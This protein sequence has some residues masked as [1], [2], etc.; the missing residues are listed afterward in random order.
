M[1]T[2]EQMQESFEQLERGTPRLNAM[3]D[4]I[5][6]ADRA[7][8]LIWQFWFR[9]DYLRESIFCGDRY[10]AMIIF[11]ELLSLYENTQMLRESKNFSHYMLIAFRWIV[12]AAPEFPQ[13]SRKE[14]DSYFRKFKRM[15]LEQ[16]YSLSIYDSKRSLFYLD[17]DFSI[18]AVSFYRFLEEE[19]DS[20]SDGKGLWYNHQVQFYLTTGDLERAEKAAEPIFSGKVKANDIPYTTYHKFCSYYVYHGN[21]AK[22]LTYAPHFE[23]YADGNPY[24]MDY[25]GTLMSLYAR[26]YLAKG[27][28]AFNRNYP[29]YMASKNPWLRSHFL[30]GT[31]HLFE[32]LAADGTVPECIVVPK[33]SPLYTMVQEEN[34]KALAEHIYA[35]AKDYAMKFDARNGTDHYTLRLEIPRDK[36]EKHV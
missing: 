33:E 1:A 35:E 27:I 17:V 12:E 25:I 16:G 18:A 36:E 21:Y 7:Q 3:R 32:R 31:L 26:L 28:K 20:V 29:L 11:P 34:V 23:N 22:A 8:N 9:Y 24:Y 30:F 13:I 14:I 15:L 5:H 6:E 2:F 19:L 10:Y 4:A